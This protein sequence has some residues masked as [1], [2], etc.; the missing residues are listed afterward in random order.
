MD[1]D[2]AQS[3]QGADGTRIEKAG[4]EDAD[5]RAAYK[6]VVDAFVATQHQLTA[7][8]FRHAELEAQL[9]DQADLAARLAVAEAAKDVCTARANDLEATLE[10]AKAERAHFRASLAWR[11]S[12]P[13][14]FLERYGNR[15]AR[16]I[17]RFTP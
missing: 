11:I 9:C 1:D 2:S 5:L 4:L 8:Q 15:F 10:R 6:V 14:R 7:L 17:R 13:L 3:D 16:M 12:M